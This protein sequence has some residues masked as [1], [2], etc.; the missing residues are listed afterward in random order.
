VRV[1]VCVRIGSVVAIRQPIRE[2]KISNLSTFLRADLLL[3]ETRM[4]RRRRSS[5]YAI[6]LYKMLQ[7]HMYNS[8]FPSSFSSLSTFLRPH[9]QLPVL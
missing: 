3:N 8:T 7:L 2:I 4:K 5:A 9:A 1:C 6:N